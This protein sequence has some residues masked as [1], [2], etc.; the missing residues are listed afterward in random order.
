MRENMYSD[1]AFA[2]RVS[3]EM[4]GEIISPAA[5]RKW[6]LGVA[7]PRRLKLIAIQ[8]VTDGAVMP[9][10]FAEAA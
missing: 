1:Q 8:R 4:G 6:R 7:M 5:V 9:N 10:S 3:I 2:D